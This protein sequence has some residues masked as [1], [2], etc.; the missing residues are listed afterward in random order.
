MA[1]CPGDEVL[2]EET[3]ASTRAFKGSLINVRVDRVR[4]ADGTETRR[5]VVEHPGAVAVLPFLDERHVVLERQFRQPTGE[6]LWE[7]P[8]GTLH[9]GEDPERCAGRELEEETG[10]SA[11]KLELLASPYL[12]P[13]YSSEVIHIFVAT[14][15]RKTE[16][17]TDHDERV[18]PVVVEFTR[19]L[20]MVRRGEIKDAKTLCAVLMAQTS[21]TR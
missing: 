11:D 13:G 18:H 17:N 16:R 6:V 21:A 3:V 8:A 15:L 20:E 1:D 7:I 19:A 5:E 4:L 9:P 12:A 2:R 10:Y 14:G